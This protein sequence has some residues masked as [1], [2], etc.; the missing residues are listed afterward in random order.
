M[1]TPKAQTEITF[2]DKWEDAKNKFNQAHVDFFE[3]KGGILNIKNSHEKTND[4][5][6]YLKQIIIIM[7]KYPNKINE[8]SSDIFSEDGLYDMIISFSL[9]NKQIELNNML[10]QVYN[11]TK[12]ES[13]GMLKQL[14]E[15]ITSEKQKTDNCE[16]T[17]LELT[18]TNKTE[19][20]KKDTDLQA[21]ITE[22]TQLNAN[23]ADLT[24]KFNDATVDAENNK[25]KLESSQKTSNDSI[26]E[27]LKTLQTISFN[28]QK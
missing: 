21:K 1:A 24:K 16:K 23:I 26:T 7:E 4:I 8:S 15:Q 11:T 12:L 18:A 17:I 6:N 2:K 14:Q 3:F 20:T 28:P 5:E 10:V 19:N 13:D 9:K 22:V 25:K 27:L